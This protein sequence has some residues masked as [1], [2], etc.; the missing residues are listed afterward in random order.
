MD[1]VPSRAS[2]ES[3]VTRSMEKKPVPA[4]LS[5]V[6]RSRLMPSRRRTATEA[7][8]GICGGTHN[9]EA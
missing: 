7:V 6:G 1:G 9:L 2:D 8:F 4:S 3:Q 5:S